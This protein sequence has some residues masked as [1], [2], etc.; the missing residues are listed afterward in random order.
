[1]NRPVLM[2]ASSARVGRFCHGIRGLSQTHSIPPDQHAA[3]CPRSPRPGR[4]QS[5]PGPASG[6][7]RPASLIP[8]LEPGK[9][10][11]VGIIP[12]GSIVR[13]V[14]AR[15]V[16][17]LGGLPAVLLQIAHPMVAQGGIRPQPL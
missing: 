16:V 17:M 8:P 1:M 7:M 9:P 10:G 15:R 13:D 14:A 6:V 4:G 12:G 3:Y 11:D 5:V 2:I